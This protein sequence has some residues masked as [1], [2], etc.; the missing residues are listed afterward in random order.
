MEQMQE[1]IELQMKWF[2]RLLL[3]PVGVLVLAIM[4]AAAVVAV[5]IMVAS[6]PIYLVFKRAIDKEFIYLNG[7]VYPG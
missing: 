5:G 4:I 3:L 2:R 1:K 7:G 6:L